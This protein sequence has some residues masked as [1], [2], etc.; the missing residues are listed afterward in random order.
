MVEN[1]N[2][3]L[4]DTETSLKALFSK[5][6]TITKVNLVYDINELELVEHKIKDAIKRK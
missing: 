3:T 4:P 1:I 2:T 5:Y 6:G